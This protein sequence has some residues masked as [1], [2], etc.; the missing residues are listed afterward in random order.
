MVDQHILPRS[1]TTTALHNA[2]KAAFAPIPVGLAAIPRVGN[3]LTGTV[4]TAPYVVLVPLWSNLSGPAYGQDRHAD[5]EW[6]YQLDA[7][8]VR[9]DQVEG[10]R[11]KALA[12]FLGKTA[13][14]YAVDLS[15]ADV[16]VT[17]RELREDLG[18]GEPVGSVIPSQFRFAVLATPNRD[19]LAVT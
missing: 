6:I 16:K 9:G 3:A 4:A 15:T 1:G 8:G 11:D 17:E 13:N 7:Y 18:I 19:A 12:V 14:G 10:M 2:L 5:A